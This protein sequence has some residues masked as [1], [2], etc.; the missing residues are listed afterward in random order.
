MI[1][2]E[3]SEYT[4][5]S[6][7]SPTPKLRSSGFS[8]QRGAR[9]AGGSSLDPVN[10]RLQL[11][12]AA[13]VLSGPASGA[14]STPHYPANHPLLC[15]ELKCRVGTWECGLV[16]SLLSVLQAC[17]PCTCVSS[18]SPSCVGS[19]TFYAVSAQINISQTSGLVLGQS[20]LGFGQGCPWMEWH[21]HCL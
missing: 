8:C 20:E 6:I 14:P 5:A 7:E 17:A 4:L 21:P 19:V 9:E 2:G 11:F 12:Q 13:S 16:F 18:L 10:L 15:L 3:T 1:E